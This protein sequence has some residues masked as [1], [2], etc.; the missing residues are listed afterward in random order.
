M[1]R[2]HGLL[3]T[4]AALALVFIAGASSTTHQVAPQLVEPVSGAK[5]TAGSKL[6]F[7]VRADQ[8]TSTGHLWLTV[9]RFPTIRNACGTIGEDVELE[10]FEPTADPTLFEAR[11]EFFDYPGFWMNTAGTYYWQAHVISYAGGAD[12]CLES[13]IRSF[14]ITPKTT[15]PPKPAPAPK[16][17]PTPAKKPLALAK[18][19]LQGN[20]EVVVRIT[21]ATGVD[22]ESLDS[23]RG[24]W[25]F[26]PSCGTGPC[27]VRLSFSYRGASF[28]TH[29]LSLPLARTGATYKGN[30]TAQFL[31]CS[32]KDVRGPIAIRL[33]VTKAAWIGGAWRATRVKGS[34]VHTAPATTS[35][36]YRCSAARMVAALKGSLER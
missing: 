1:R 32:F 26:R 13:E 22:A 6:V 33:N 29:R 30:G 36:I 11:P 12:G 27:A 28:D 19:R 21:S 25:T 3:L 7:S 20:F 9:S 17:T 4:A 23:D 35:G 31:E 5:F 18:A 16:P 10:S 34:Y 14:T 24:T 8:Y 15:P 2:L